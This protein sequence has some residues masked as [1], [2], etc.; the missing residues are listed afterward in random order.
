M[1]AYHQVYDSHHLQADFQEPGSAPEP[2]T[3]YRVWATFYLITIALIQK[4]QQPFPTIP[5]V[6]KP[7]GDIPWFGSLLWVF[8]DDVTLLVG[9]Q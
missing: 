9:W 8:F 3:R 2:Y 5:V 7:M 1:A 4:E 6:N